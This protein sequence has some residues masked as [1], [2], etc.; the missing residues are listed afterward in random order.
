MDRAVVGS[1]RGSGRGR[2]VREAVDHDGELVLD[3]GAALTGMVV[4][5]GLAHV[6]LDDV[7]R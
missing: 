5:E 4:A 3:G 2:D 7:G 1:R 6:V